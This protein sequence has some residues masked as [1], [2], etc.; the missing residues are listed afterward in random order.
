M[1][2]SSRL[3]SPAL[4]CSLL[5]FVAACS[6][7]DASTPSSPPDLS[8]F[9]GTAAV[10]GSGTSGGGGQGGGGG[11]VAGTP[12]AGSG[13]APPDVCVAVPQGKLA[14]L[15]DFEDGD[16]VA[17]AEAQREA[18]WFTVH[19][20]SAGSIE[21]EGMLLPQPPGKDSSSYAMHVVASGYTTWGASVSLS[22]SYVAADVRCPYNAAGFK[23]IRFEAKGHGHFRVGVPIRETVDKEYG[24]SCD[25]DKGMICYDQH[26]APV[27]LGEAWQS[28]EIPWSEL[29]QRG[30]GTPAELR[31]DAIQGLQLTFDPDSLPIDVWLD[32]V[33]LWDGVTKPVAASNG[34]GGQGG[35]AGAG[36][37]G[38]E[39]GHAEP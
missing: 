13:G 11:S 12:S 15:D 5:G 22:L 2:A 10:G 7:S 17:R 38:G 37:S 28:Y 18:Y 23:G 14:L 8:P 24:G 26:T 4:V 30:W 25:P 20:D 19:D 33:E 27:T 1:A 34:E 31:P 35:E 21:P 6:S 16:S 39:G 29:V 32:N 36:G 3:V 9:G